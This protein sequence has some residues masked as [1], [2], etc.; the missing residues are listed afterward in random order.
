MRLLLTIALAL[1]ATLFDVSPGRADNR[2]A[3]VVGNGAYRNVPALANSPADAKAIAKSLARLGFSVKVIFDSTYDEFRRALI[4]FG[5]KARTAD[6]AVVYFAGHG[7]E[8]NGENGL[9]PVDAEL[10]TDIDATNET[11]E[12]NS[13]MRVVSSAKKL[14]LVILDACRNSQFEAKMQGVS[15]ARA[16]VNQGLAPVEPSG[17]VLVAYAAI[18]GTTSND[19]DAR[20]HS[21]Y[22]ATLLRHIETPGLEIGYLFRNVRDDVMEETRGLQQP[23]TYGSRSGDEIYLVD[24][25]A[26]AQATATPEMGADQI[27]WSFLSATTNID[28]LRRFVSEYPN[29]AYVAAATARI[30]LLEQAA[31]PAIPNNV[32]PQSSPNTLP[33]PAQAALAAAVADVPKPQVVARRFH[34]DTPAIESA[35]KVVRQSKDPAVIRQFADQFPNQ[36]RRLVARDRLVDLG[37]SPAPVRVRRQ[38]TYVATADPFADQSFGACLSSSPGEV[39]ISACR[40]A[41]IRFPEIP[42]IRTRLCNL[43]GSAN[44]ELPRTPHEQGSATDPSATNTPGSSMPDPSPNAANDQPGSS[45]PNAPTNGDAA[46]GTGNAKVAANATGSLDKA[47]NATA[48]RYTTASISDPPDQSAPTALLKATAARNNQ[49][50]NTGPGASTNN[51]SGNAKAATNNPSG[52]T[53]PGASTNNQSGNAKAVT[54]HKPVNRPGSPLRSRAMS[55][56]S[57]PANI[58]NAPTDTSGVS[59]L[60]S[61][62]FR[63]GGRLPRAPVTAALTARTNIS[64]NA[65]K[66]STPRVTSLH[67]S[68]PKVN[69][70]TPKVNVST[71]KVNVS[72]PKVNVSTNVS[73]P[74]VNV[75]IPKVNVSTPKVTPQ[76]IVPRVSAPNVAVK[77]PTVRAPTVRVPTIH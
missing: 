33:Q 7:I 39:A 5:R 71:P 11:I 52:N 60:G 47:A 66:L 55:L 68:T 50:G 57:A 65:V 38:P 25:P 16:M 61:K 67:V 72:T 3:F 56:S 58:S 22:T 19:D 4:E 24:L 17:N 23:H 46:S 37:Q 31:A 18:D 53:G 63:H 12:L 74:K 41:Y 8:I 29:S 42:I 6:I 75:S 54:Y 77:V 34:K 10:K 44:C 15:P 14:G 69:V 26:G 35:W 62:S 36:Q 48:P 70:S 21:L 51:Q 9:I 64:T 59:S 13:V 45:M 28:T 30:A 2:V 43:L 40:L 1:F 20:P 73:I 32:N 76:I 27:A 49:S